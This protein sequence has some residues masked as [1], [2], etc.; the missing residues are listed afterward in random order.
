MRCVFLTA[1][2]GH[3]AVA[4]GALPFFGLPEDRYLSI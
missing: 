4:I 2:N 3:A 1:I